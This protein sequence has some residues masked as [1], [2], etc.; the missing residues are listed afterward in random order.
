MNPAI[1]LPR[2]LDALAVL[3]PSTHREVVAPDGPY[4]SIPT[5]VLSDG[6]DPWWATATADQILQLIMGALNA[7]APAGFCCFYSDGDRFELV[8]YEEPTP[9]REPLPKAPSTRRSSAVRCRVLA[10]EP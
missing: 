7:A 4:A 3:S 2:L 9:H 5:Q 8:R 10:P 1:V 6:A